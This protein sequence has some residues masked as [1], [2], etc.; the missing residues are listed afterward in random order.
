MESTTFS[1][2]SNLLSL[3]SRTPVTEPAKTPEPK[4]QLPTLSQ[5]LNQQKQINNLVY[6]CQLN[7]EGKLSCNW[8]KAC[9]I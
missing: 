4:S 5:M 9:S 6:V 1:P 8:V 2:L 7:H 3:F